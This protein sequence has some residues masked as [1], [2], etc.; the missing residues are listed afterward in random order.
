M[1]VHSYRRGHG[2]I[3][4]RTKRRAGRQREHFRCFFESTRERIGVRDG[5]VTS[6]DLTYAPPM[7]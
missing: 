4:A 6:H 3:P 7:Y 5:I 1:L 2:G